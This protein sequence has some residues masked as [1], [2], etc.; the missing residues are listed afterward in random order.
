M[1]RNSALGSWRP[2]MRR[3]EETEGGIPYG[4]QRD[5][6]IAYYHDAIEEISA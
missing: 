4:Y 5:T 1:P 2:S 6:E 3:A